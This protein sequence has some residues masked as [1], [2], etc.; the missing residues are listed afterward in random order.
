MKKVLITGSNGLL[1]Q[2]IVELLSHTL[3]GLNLVSLES[4]S[5]F[6]EEILPYDQLDL[7]KR[8]DVRKV[9]DSFEPDIIV[10][11]AA[12][13]DVDLCEKERGL[14]WQVNVGSVENLAYA[15]KLV[16]A[17]IIHISTDYVFD[18]NNGPYTESDRPNPISYYGRTK[19]A[20]ENVLLT[21]DV[22]SAILRTMVLYGCGIGIKQNFALWLYNNLSEKKPV[23][24]VDDQIGNPT[25]VDD[26][27][28]AI[29]KIIELNKTG[30]YNIAGKDIVS[31]YDFALSLANVFSFNKKL[32]TPV[33]SSIFKQPAPRPLN[34]GLIILK[35]QT[36]LNLSMSGIER[37]ITI[38]KNQLE[39]IN[40]QNSDR[41]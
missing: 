14:A 4:R 26:L 34:S 20:S 39:T 35:A 31:R 37:G 25:L 32:I 36:E 23:K 24:V 19:L 18:G 13:T 8:Q 6:D 10:N 40:A 2:K 7:T 15:A 3:Y 22:P 33:K 1:G 5:V 38:F 41:R 17:K 16:G 27:A 28:L 9:V 12:V 30:I 11:T 21:S 29:L